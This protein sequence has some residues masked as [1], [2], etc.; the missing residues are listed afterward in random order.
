M[1]G[2]T[3]AVVALVILGFGLVSKRLQRSVVTPPMVFVTAGFLVSGQVLGLVHLEVGDRALTLLAEFTLVLILFT[4]ATRIH[5]PTLRRDY[6]LPL[7]L[8]GIGLPLTVLLGVVAGRVLLPDLGF[9]EVLLVAAILAPT[10][11]A[12][13]QAVVSNPKVPAR[14]RQALNVESGLNDGLVLPAVLIFMALADA[15]DDTASVA[16][17][18]RFTAGQLILGPLVGCAIAYAGGRIVTRATRARWMTHTFQ[19]LSALALAILAYT[20]AEMVGGNGFIAAFVA[21]LTLGAT[22]REACGPLLDFS[23]TEGQLLTLVVFMIFGG[24]VV[25]PVLREL[26]WLT[27]AYG[28]I[29]LTAARM[30]AVAVSLIGSGLHARTVLFLGWFGPRGVA[31]IVFGLMTL[32]RVIAHREEIFGIVIAT[33]LMS[34][35]AHGLTAVPG[36]ARYAAHAEAMKVGPDM[37]EHMPVTEL[38]VRIPHR[39]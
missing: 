32:E 18:V 15:L 37:P 7:R 16:F 34:V 9:Y 4:D 13:G 8:L 22:A 33:V 2:Q 11:A 17:W 19:E 6:H 23:E 35:F 12:L 31:S 29:S 24:V 21:G 1:E 36:A 25:W 28:A 3:L 38:P 5:L 14:I 26:H 10:D 20:L 39:I 27:L 30:L